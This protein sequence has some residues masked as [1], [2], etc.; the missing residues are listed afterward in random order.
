M[1]AVV[2]TGGKQVRV[3]PGDLVDLDLIEGEPGQRVELAEVLMIGGEQITVGRPLVA[4]AKVVATIQGDAKG[5]KLRIFKFKR[6][7]R[8]RLT[9]GHRQHFTRVKIDSIEV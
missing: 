1:Y 3:Q 2:R 4:G 6:R 5:P 8:Y 7:K 9:K